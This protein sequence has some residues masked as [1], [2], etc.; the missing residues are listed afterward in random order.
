MQRNNL[1]FIQFFLMTLLYLN[2]V[3]VK[4]EIIEKVSN[5][6]KICSSALHWISTEL[7]VWETNIVEI[8]KITCLLPQ[9]LH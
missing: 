1:H 6:L 7:T 2:A 5:R 8:D 4:K 3:S 9:V